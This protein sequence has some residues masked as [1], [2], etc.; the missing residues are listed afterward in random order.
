MGVSL[1]KKNV[2]WLIPGRIASFRQLKNSNNRCLHTVNV[3]LAFDSL[4][5]F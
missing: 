3:H 1:L 4:L 2:T 5:V